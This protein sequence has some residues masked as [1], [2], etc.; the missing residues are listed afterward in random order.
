MNLHDTLSEQ[1]DALSGFFR[2]RGFSPEDA[3]DLA[4]ETLYR[5]LKNQDDVRDTENPE[6][7]LFAIARNV[8]IDQSRRTAHRTTEPLA[9]EL[10]PGDDPEP[11]NATCRC[12]LQVIDQLPED[13]ARLI[14]LV[15]LEETPQSIAAAQLD[16]SRNTLKVQVF[17]ARKQLRE[18]LEATCGACATGS[19]C[20]DCS[21]GV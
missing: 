5:A 7:W 16:I 18:M 10:E 14:R 17:R 9:P 4:Q 15:D 13:Q 8:A 1:R 19:H 11:I 6:G 21:C 12:V 2:S 20:L 3:E